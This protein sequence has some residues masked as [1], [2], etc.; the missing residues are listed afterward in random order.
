MISSKHFL[1]VLFCVFTLLGCQPIDY[2]PSPTYNNYFPV[3][4]ND[5]KEYFVTSIQHTSFGKDTSTYF[6]KEILTEDFIDDEGDLAYRMER[7]WKV[8]SLAE[9]Q[10]K[11]VWVTKKKMRSAELVEE[12]ERFIKMIFPLTHY[13]FWDGNA[14]N[15]RPSQE[16]VI[17][18]LHDYYTINGFEFDSTVTIMQHQKSNLIEYEIAKEV[19]AMDIGLIYKE[20]ILININNGNVADVNY[21][22]EYRK[23]LIDY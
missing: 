4:I 8:D 7:F 15:S 19:Y 6:L 2:N 13:V 18:G 16:Y 5:T 12:N 23:E 11:D 20:D 14:Y 1:L 21:G 10:I 17:E 3:V 9:Y 22:S